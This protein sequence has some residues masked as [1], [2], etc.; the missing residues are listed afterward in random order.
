MGKEAALEGD[1]CLCSCK[2]SPRLIGVT[3]HSYQVI[4]EDVMTTANSSW[5]DKK[6]AVDAGMQPDTYRR[7]S[8]PFSVRAIVENAAQNSVCKAKFLKIS[9]IV[10]FNEGGYVNDPN[11]SGGPTNKG[12]AWNTWKAYAK[13]DIGV[14][15]TLENLKALTD[16]QANV[17]YWKRYWEPR[18]FC[19]VDNEK[20][21]LNIY[22]WTITSGQAIKKIQQMLAI[23]FSKSISHDNKMSTHFIECINSISDQEHLSQKI[24]AARKK[25]YASLSFNTDG[26]TNKNHR[27]LKGWLSR[28]DRCLAYQ[29][30]S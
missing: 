27:F 8:A 10:L 6:F 29:M 25:Y 17:I 21:A 23:D 13:E 30:E 22:D 15:P 24:G 4:G 14:E 3:T 11:D 16:D 9:D 12:I 26:T 28:V 5:Q 18:R 19:E 20:T 2:P 1:I 7:T